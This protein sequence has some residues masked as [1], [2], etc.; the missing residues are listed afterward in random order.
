MTQQRRTALKELQKLDVS[1]QE[2]RQRIQD[3]DPLLEEVEEPALVLEGELGTSR[4]RLKEMTLEERRLELSLEEKKDRLK[5]LDERVASVRNLREEA[6]VSAELEMVRRALQ[7]DEQEALALL[8]QIR[9]GEERV[10]EL[11]AA[12]AEAGTLVEPKRDE[13]LA[14]K[15]QA[16]KDLEALERERESFE[17]GIDPAE[18]RVYD[19]I[20]RGGRSAAVSELTDDGA[21]GN[22]FGIVPPQL[23]NEVRHGDALIRCEAC[24]VI[25]AAP[26]PVEEGAEEAA[27]EE[28]AAEE[29]AAEET[30]AEETAAEET[31]AEE[32]AAEETTA[33]EDAAEA[34][35]A[36]ADTG[37][38]EEAGGDEEEESGGDP[39]SADEGEEKG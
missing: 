16:G 1:I 25:L 39:A 33:E 2:V 24:G 30:T 28:T 21:C 27:P 11:E 15:E 34:V 18:I 14:Q 37:E 38:P 26:E 5:R 4:N 36:D 13:L 17:A 31:A 9:K 29:D 8:D 10:V 32:T 7:N 20:R 12:F 23:Q 22:C 19:A 35:D 6:A 3:F